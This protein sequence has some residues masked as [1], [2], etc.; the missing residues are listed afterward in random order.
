MS[1]DLKVVLEQQ[2][3]GVAFALKTVQAIKESAASQLNNVK[4]SMSKELESQLKAQIETCELIENRISMDYAKESGSRVSANTQ[5]RL[6]VD[7]R[8]RA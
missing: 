4:F 5:F 6:L 2:D 7:L 8:N 1:Q 3:A